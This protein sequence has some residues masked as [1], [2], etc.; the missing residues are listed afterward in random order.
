MSAAVVDQTVTTPHDPPVETGIVRAYE[1]GEI[2]LAGAP[3]RM[4]TPYPVPCPHPH[5][6]TRSIVFAE[7]DAEVER[8]LHRHYAEVPH[9]PERTP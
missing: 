8:L 5:C 3:V 2:R 1:R 4:R 7:D 6:P 9:Y